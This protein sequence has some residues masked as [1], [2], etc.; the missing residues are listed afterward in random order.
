MNTTLNQQVY[1]S[2]E[3][4][5]KYIKHLNELHEVMKIRC[6]LYYNLKVSNLQEFY[7]LDKAI[8]FDCCG[9]TWIKEK[10][11]KRTYQ[12]EEYSSKRIPT[13]QDRCPFCGKEFNLYSLYDYY[14]E[15][16]EFYHKQ[17]NL[18]NKLD[19]QKR[20]FA[21]I[22][23]KIY[24]LSELDF[25]AIPNQYDDWEGYAPWFIITT[26]DGKIKI[27]WRKHVISIEWLNDYKPFNERFVN[28]DV[29]KNFNNEERYIHAW[30]IEKCIEYLTKAKNS[31]SI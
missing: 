18:F 12:R 7:I 3:G 11:N 19:I 4:L 10:D 13:E 24:T 5:D 28:E 2:Q 27:G 22:F 16:G 17:C 8:F 30:S 29:T 14:Q 23:S 15:G 31:I 6:D 9:N 26:P 21:D 20:E 25:K 1:N